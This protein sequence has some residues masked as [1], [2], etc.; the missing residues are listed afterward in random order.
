MVTRS[1]SPQGYGHRMNHLEQ[2]VSEWLQYRGYF[3]R[4]SVAVGARAK[5]GFEGE[6]D[7]VALNP[8]TQHLLHVECSLDALSTEQ[9]QLRF[10]GKFE[11]GRK[12]IKDAFR[13]IEL[14]E[15][16]EQVLVLQFASGNVRS[17]GGARLVTVREFVHEMFDGL[18]GTSP[19]SKAVPSNLPLLRTIQ[20][21]A[22]ATRI[23]ANGHRIISEAQTSEH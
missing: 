4:Q 9:R 3:V 7:V 16:L 1:A 12:Y 17:I 21:A 20:L 18:K 15:T 2:L 10:S 11:R 13:G 6:L 8:V 19:A 14:P 22:D 23:R 5:G